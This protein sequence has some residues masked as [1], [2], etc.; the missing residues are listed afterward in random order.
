MDHTKLHQ[1]DLDL[2]AGSFLYVVSGL[3]QPFR[4]FGKLF[5]WVCIPEEQFSCRT[6]QIHI[7]LVV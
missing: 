3:S 4:F 6:N 5:F 1:A 7:Q 2:L